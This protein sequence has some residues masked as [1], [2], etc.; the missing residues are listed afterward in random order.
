MTQYKIVK[1]ISQK[2]MESTVNSLIKKGWTAQGGL[3]IINDEY[4]ILTF[5]QVMV[6]E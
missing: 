5:Y 6:K 3:Q 1:E 2:E 4:D